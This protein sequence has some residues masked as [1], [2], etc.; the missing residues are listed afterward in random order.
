MT[1]EQLAEFK[2]LL[3]TRAQQ[4]KHNIADAAQEINGLIDS[5]A[6]DDTDFAMT[7]S[8]SQLEMSISTQQQNELHEI[9]Y[10]LGKIASGG[11]YGVCEMCE[12][13]IDIERL[14]AKPHAKYCII[15]REIVEKNAKGK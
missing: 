7:L 12:E 10:A 4:I 5:G 6:T 9:A 3:Q 8:N 15:C 14:R 1:N 11:G 13:E 2:G